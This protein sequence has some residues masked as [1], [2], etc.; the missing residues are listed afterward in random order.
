MKMWN[1]S[2]LLVAAVALSCGQRNATGPQGGTGPSDQKPTGNAPWVAITEASILSDSQMKITFEEYEDDATST[3]FQVFIDEKSHSLQ[4]FIGENSA[5]FGEMTCLQEVSG[6]CRTYEVSTHFGVSYRMQHLSDMQVI[7]RSAVGEKTFVYPLISIQEKH[8]N[9]N[10]TGDFIATRLLDAPVVHWM[11]Y[12]MLLPKI[13]AVDP[14]S[15]GMT[16]SL[17]EPLSFYQ[18]E[19]LSQTQYSSTASVFEGTFKHLLTGQQ[20]VIQ[21]EFRASL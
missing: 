19:A 11:E 18:F 1:L 6:V 2:L 15:F 12:T 4:A 21:W 9:S 16:G 17:K 8:A 5:V 13:G 14:L 7:V 3:Q 20:E 10:V